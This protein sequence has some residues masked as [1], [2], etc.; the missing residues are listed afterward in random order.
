MKNYRKNSKFIDSSILNSATFNDYMERFEKVARSIF[1]WVNLPSSMNERWL[2]RSLYLKGSATILFDENFGFINTDCSTAGNINIYGLPTELNCYSFEYSKKRK[3]YT[4][5]IGLSEETK[6]SMKNTH[7]ILVQNNYERT[8]TFSTMELFALRLYEVERTIDTNIKAMKTPVL[9]LVDE[10]QRLTLQNIY[11]QYDGNQ[12]VIF[13]DKNN[14]TEGSPISSIKTEA[15]FLADK[16]TDYK[17][18][19]WNEALTYLRH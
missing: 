9:I 18:E 1:E 14:F 3:L 10:K 6:N 16:L 11:N 17:K 12:P 7:C 4:G 5:N 13:G 2:E 15:P 19:I 8:P